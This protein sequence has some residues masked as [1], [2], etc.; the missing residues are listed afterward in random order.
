MDS[1]TQGLLGA[2]IAQAGFR[3]KLG[4]KA[5]AI[6]AFLAIAPDFDIVSRLWSDEWNTIAYHRAETHSL[7]LLLIAAFPIAYGF[8]R[9]TKRAAGYWWW[10]ALCLLTLWSAPL[11]DACTVYGTQLLAPFSRHRFSWDLIA[12]IDPIYSVPL[13]IATLLALIKRPALRGYC[14]IVAMCALIWTCMYLLMSFHF[15]SRGV[16][17]QFNFHVDSSQSDV[18]DQVQAQETPRKVGG[19]EVSLNRNQRS[20][21]FIGSNL[22]WR[23]IVKQTTSV[24]GR[25]LPE[26]FYVSEPISAF[27]GWWPEDDMTEHS[28]DTGE[29]TRQALATEKGELIW[30]FSQGWLRAEPIYAPDEV[31]QIGVLFTDMRYGLA[32]APASSPFRFQA[33]Y[34]E[35]TNTW[36]WERLKRGF[37]DEDGNK[38][39]LT[40]GAIFDELSYTYGLAFEPIL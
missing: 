2:T 30:W 40:P 25:Y 11:L 31:K 8:W 5:V 22:L 15:K 6:G 1:I 9:Y 4:G 19:S 35:A 38:R 3:H 29:M 17:N 32:S 10:F 37:T 26:R 12:I 33:M 18:T 24:A 23:V 28:S 20:T 16:S 13:L 39:S 36:S 21:P 34:D 14:Q 27:R 7:P